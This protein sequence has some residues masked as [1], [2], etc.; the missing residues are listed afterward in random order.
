MDNV[1]TVLDNK[2]HHQLRAHL[3]SAYA[4]KGID[5]QQQLADEQI[6]KLLVLLERKYL[7][8]SDVV[9]PCNLAR[10]MQYLTQDVIT[11]LAFGVPAGYLDADKDMYGVL[12][13]SELV[14]LPA[15]IIS[16][17]SVLQKLLGTSL[18]K[19]FL[20]K[21]SDKHSIGR[22]LGVVKSYVDTRYDPGKSR[23]NDMLQGFVDSGLSRQQVESEALVTLFGGTDTTSTGLRN[24]IFYLATNPS[25][26]HSLQVEI[27]AA[28]RMATRPVIADEHVKT[29]SY[30]QACI[31]EGLRL[32]PP[33]MGLMAKMSDHDDVV[34]GF[35]IPAK[36]QVGWAAL[37]VMKNP[38]V[39]GEN[40]HVFEPRRWIDA[41]PAKLKEMEA[42][43]G[44]V[45][46]T[47]TRWECLGKR[48]AYVE[49]GKVLFEVIV[50]FPH[51]SHA[52]E[53][54]CI[55]FSIVSTLR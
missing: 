1:L 37:A 12:K 21:P 17:S 15:H 34:C 46:A 9:R 13:A 29:L 48:L 55:S 4:G 3:L 28:A 36:T 7:S 43:Y 19:P 10:T 18:I 41:D 39:F 33:S 23:N 20:P 27:D 5:N 14:L 44:L 32:W 11:A 25:A 16:F 35:K 40:S 26:Y 54:L 51:H 22:F 42:V 53:G 45:F 8:T 31:R 24:T 52:D 38:A 50:R 6:A 49:L 47:G 30:L 2:A